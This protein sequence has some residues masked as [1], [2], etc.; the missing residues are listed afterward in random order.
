M[1]EDIKRKLKPLLMKSRTGQILTD[2]QQSFVDACFKKF[3]KEYSALHR[4]VVDESIRT[5]NPF[6]DKP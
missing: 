6:W 1:E 2:E 5:V 4:E 3:P